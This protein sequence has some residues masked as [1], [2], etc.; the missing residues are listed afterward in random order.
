MDGTINKGRKIEHAVT[1]KLKHARKDVCHQFFVADI[2]PNNFIFGYPFLE[3]ASL[4]IDWNAGRIFGLV[5]VST[6]DAE[7]W[8]ILPRGTKTR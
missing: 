7:R 2:G 1:L 6:E 4:N 5:T 3:A 8:K